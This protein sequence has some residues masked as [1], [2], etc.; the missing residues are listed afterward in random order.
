M[1]TPLP[2]VLSSLLLVVATAA[3]ADYY[4]VVNANNPQSALTRSEALNLFMG[5]SRA[6]ANG[7]F[8]LVFDLPRDSTKREGF[9][10]SLTGLSLAQITSYWARLMF[11]GQSLPPQP[12][13]DETTM[14]EIVKHNPSAVGWLSSAPADKGLH[15]VL[16][17]KE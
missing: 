5:R 11:S 8:A 2:L 10:R 13:P 9:Y 16:V 1:R 15:T 12:L 4:V 14:V 6:F 7:D 17:L 3:R